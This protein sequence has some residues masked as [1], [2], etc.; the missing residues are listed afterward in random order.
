MPREPGYYIKQ[1]LQH[2]WEQLL[3]ETEKLCTYIYSQGILGAMDVFVDESI[4]QIIGVLT[5]LEAF[6]GLG[7]M[8]F[9]VKDSVLSAVSRCLRMS[10]GVESREMAIQRALVMVGMLMSNRQWDEYGRDGVDIL[11]ISMM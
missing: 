10:R 6:P 3:Y 9:K 11:Q 5:A 1:L 7:H 8:R 2:S 4:E